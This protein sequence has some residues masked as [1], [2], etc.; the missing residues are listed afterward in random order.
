MF[1]RV[2]IANPKHCNESTLDK[3]P[4]HNSRLSMC[5]QE[6]KKKHTGKSFIFPRKANP[7]SG[8]RG[9]NRKFS[10][11]LEAP[12]TSFPGDLFTLFAFNDQ[13]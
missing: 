7:P 3:H 1:D 12:D 6:I 2:T 8:D 5:R 4:L 10:L 11:K 13:V 9:L